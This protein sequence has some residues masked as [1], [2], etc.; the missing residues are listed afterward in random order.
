MSSGGDI[1]EAQFPD[2][3]QGPALRARP[4][5]DQTRRANLPFAMVCPDACLSSLP[6][7]Q[8]ELGLTLSQNGGRPGTSKER[9][10]ME[11]EVALWS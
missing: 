8:P 3:R 11:E 10:G 9:T 1:P 7:R 6:T 2:A 5:P 4:S